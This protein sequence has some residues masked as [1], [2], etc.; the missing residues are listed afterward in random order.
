MSV[1]ECVCVCVGVVL[2]LSDGECECVRVCVTVVEGWLSSSNLISHFD[3]G[4]S[5]EGGSCSNF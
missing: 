2:V 5:G 3:I 1:G 4:K